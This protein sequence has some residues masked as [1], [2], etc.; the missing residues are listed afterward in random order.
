[1]GGQRDEKNSE[2][3]SHWVGA[4]HVILTILPH[5]GKSSP[6]MGRTPTGKPATPRGKSG[7]IRTGSRNVAPA[8]Y[9]STSSPSAST[10]AFTATCGLV[11]SS[12]IPGAD[13]LSSS[14]P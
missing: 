12:A 3:R 1:C 10:P 5:A 2:D 7:R 9:T 13:R 4:R 6:V 14:E 11:A 8:Q